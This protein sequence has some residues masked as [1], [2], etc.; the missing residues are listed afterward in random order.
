MKIFRIITLTLC[1]VLATTFINSVSYANS[2]NFEIIDEYQKDG[3]PH[4]SLI[5]LANNDEI[6]VQ[7]TKSNVQVL[8]S[9]PCSG[10]SKEKGQNFVGHINA[11]CDC[12]SS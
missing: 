8:E 4:Y 12:V 6:T 3:L 7:Y 10:L 1:M 2:R 5:C 11:I 9:E